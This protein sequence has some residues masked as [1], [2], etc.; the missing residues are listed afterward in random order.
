[1][2]CEVK[3]VYPVDGPEPCH[4]VEVEISD[5]VGRVNVR[6][7]T[8]EWPGKPPSSWQVAWDERVLNGDGT[9]DV[10]GR[11]PREV[12]ANGAALRLAF[13]FHYFDLSRPLLTPAGCVSLPPAVRRP[14][15]LAFM[16]YERP[17]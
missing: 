11:F 14:E 4:L 1:M 12:V 13:F 7:F 17:D 15:R 3:G 8:Q 6:G 5:H 10:A 16:Q 2:H 9:E